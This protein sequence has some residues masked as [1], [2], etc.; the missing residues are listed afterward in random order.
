M[1]DLDQTAK[2]RYPTTVPK[3][4]TGWITDMTYDG[5]VPGLDFADRFQTMNQLPESWG[6]DAKREKERHTAARVERIRRNEARILS[7]AFQEEKVGSVV[8]V[9]SSF[10]SK[11]ERSS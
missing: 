11:H 1:N 5:P 2:L 4:E 6:Q 8:S 3:N 9:V 7:V 10:V